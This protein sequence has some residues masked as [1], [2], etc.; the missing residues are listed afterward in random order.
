MLE[1]G[2]SIRIVREAKGM[3]LSVLAGKGG[4]SVPFL[5]LVENGKRQPSLVVLRRLAAA[6]AIPPEVLIILAQP[7]EGCLRSGDPESQ[8]LVAAIQKMLLVE[9]ELR[10]K[11]APEAKT[12]ESCRDD[13]S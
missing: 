8:S 5:S 12:D 3:S 4:V 6:L 11:L 9:K 2:R 10:S 1:L 7:P 13:G